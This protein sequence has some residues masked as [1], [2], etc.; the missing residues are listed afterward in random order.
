MQ[1]VTERGLFCH[2]FDV[3]VV[4]VCSLDDTV[5]PH[6]LPTL[7]GIPASAHIAVRY[8]NIRLVGNLSQWLN[9]HHQYL[10]DKTFCRV[11]LLC[12]SVTLSH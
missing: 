5:V 9:G 3:T 2:L 8:T 7:L 1:W 10:G 4:C 11:Y 12:A 6:I